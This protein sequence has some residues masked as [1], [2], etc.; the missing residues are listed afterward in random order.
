MIT[1]RQFNTFEDLFNYYNSELFDGELPEVMINMSRK[2]KSLGFFAPERWQAVNNEEKVHEIS[3]NPDYLHDDPLEWHSTL[4]HEMCHLWEQHSGRTTKG[5]YHGKKWGDK[6]EAI[7][8]MP[9][10]TG[11]PGGKKTGSRMDHYIIP[12]GRYKRAFEVIQGEDF[13]E[14]ILPYVPALPAP[15]VTKEGNPSKQGLKI[16]YTC[17]CGNNVWGKPDLKLTCDSCQEAYQPNQD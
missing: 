3:L 15:K 4:V 12:D 9:S 11:A 1:K 7:G 5:G 10:D 6:M 2:K 17:A 16:K 13:T 14:M 8:L